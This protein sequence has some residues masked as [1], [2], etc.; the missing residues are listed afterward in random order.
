M[1]PTL[2]LEKV[3]KDGKPAI[4]RVVRYATPDLRELLDTL[5]VTPDCS[6]ANCRT[7]VCGTPAELDAVRKRLITMF[8]S[9][10]QWL[11]MVA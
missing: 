2:Q 1:N 5:G 7:K 4:R 11:G 10:G 8:D 6:I 9:K 3:M